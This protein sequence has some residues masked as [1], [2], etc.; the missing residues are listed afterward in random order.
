MQIP[1]D[2]VAASCKQA[3]GIFTPVI[4]R[5]KCEGKGPCAPACP[6]KAITPR[7]A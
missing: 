6:K 3:P 1:S 2:A 4:K 7:R 5:E